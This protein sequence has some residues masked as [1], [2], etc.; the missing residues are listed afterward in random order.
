MNELGLTPKTRE[1]PEPKP[2]AE[3]DRFPTWSISDASSLW[4]RASIFRLDMR[5][6]IAKSKLKTKGRMQLQSI[7]QENEINIYRGIP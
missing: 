4:G 1:K 7:W 6:G 2:S 5:V 3:D